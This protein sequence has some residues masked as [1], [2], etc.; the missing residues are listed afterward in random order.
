MPGHFSKKELWCLRNEIP[1]ND[2]ICR[3]LCLPSKVCDAL[4]RFQCPLCHCTHTATNKATNLA[5]C[6]NCKKNF[7]TI[8]LVMAARASSFRGS[9]LFL[10]QFAAEPQ[11]PMPGQPNRPVS[12]NTSFLSVDEVLRRI[13]LRVE[14]KQ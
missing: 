10:K 7:N 2:L 13:A 14:E 1:I 4:L 5:R 12:S 9:V 6:F 3:K 11:P 8:D